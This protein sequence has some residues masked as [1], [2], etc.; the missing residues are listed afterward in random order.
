[1]KSKSS[2]RLFLLGFILFIVFLVLIAVPP[3]IK[4]N[5]QTPDFSSFS[6]AANCAEGQKTYTGLAN[7]EPDTYDVY[8]RLGLKDQRAQVSVY[9]ETFGSSDCALVGSL[10]ATA[11]QW[12]KVGSIKLTQE[13]AFGNFVLAS[14]TLESLPSANRPTIML[15]SQTK[16][17][18]QPTD[19]CHVNID[20][21]QAVLRASG[22]VLGSD[23]LSII[24]VKDPTTD[25]IVR[26]DYYVDNKPAYSSS[27]LQQFDRRFVP[28]GKHRL[29]TVITYE[30]KQQAV[31]A[32]S[33]DLGYV[34]DLNY[35]I[36]SYFTSKKS[37]WIVVGIVVGVFAAVGL[38]LH[39]TH[40]LYA[41][42]LWK[43][44]HILGQEAPSD[45]QHIH[46][47][48][49]VSKFYNTLLRSHQWLIGMVSHLPAIIIS[50]ILVVFVFGFFMR[51][52]V[53]LYSVDGPSMK[54]TYATGDL[55]VVN[56]L[57]KSVSGLLGKQFIPKR[58]EVVVFQKQRNVA[59]ESVE[60][61]AATYLVK[62]VVGLPGE[63]VVVKSADITVINKDSPEGFNPDKDKP[64]TSN[65]HLSQID[66]VDVTLGADEVFV[67]GDNRPESVDSRNFGPVKLYEIVGSTSWF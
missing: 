53:Q 67:V 13:N 25:S 30:S 46:P 41:R 18:C 45:D 52:S 37:V 56:K 27:T 36:F 59:F 14:P 42:H 48:E 40:K 65:L 20:G 6:N 35:W 12:S 2:I 22:G 50:T 47:V 31:I 26:V 16:P 34:D 62:R 63:R 7:A 39:L 32:E 44:T 15:V 29:A 28:S 1:M 11:A 4:L 66:D 24:T 5:A 10:E 58:G 17:V 55:L 21:R 8:V 3:Q 38:A 9:K 60:A 49:E 61:G 23:S 64:W 19:E 57:G 43:K 51:W 54:N 33:V